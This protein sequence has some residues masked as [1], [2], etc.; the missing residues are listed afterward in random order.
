LKHDYFGTFESLSE[1]EK[2]CF[3]IDSGKNCEGTVPGLVEKLG[4]AHLESYDANAIKELNV[5]RGAASLANKE[6]LW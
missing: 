3:S 2:D 1:E 5:N 4:V 6:K